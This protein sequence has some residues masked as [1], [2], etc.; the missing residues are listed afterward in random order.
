MAIEH[1][2][3]AKSGKLVKVKNYTRGK[4]IK[5]HCT[6][7]MGWETHP[8]E[9]TDPNCPSYPYRGKVLITCQN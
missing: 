7:C 3:R 9:C 1:T 6:E 5:V 4:A 2:V 8:K